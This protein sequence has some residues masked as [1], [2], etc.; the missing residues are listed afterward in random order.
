MIHVASLLHDDVIDNAG[1]R[2]PLRLLHT[3]ACAWESRQSAQALV[4]SGASVPKC[5]AACVPQRA[6]REAARRLGCMDGLHHW[7]RAPGCMRADVR[8]GLRA[9][10]S[11]FGNKIAVLAG[12]FLLARASVSLAALR[13][14]EVIQLLSQVIEDLVTGEILQARAPGAWPLAPRPVRLPRHCRFQGGVG[15]ACGFQRCQ[16]RVNWGLLCRPMAP[17]AFSNSICAGQVCTPD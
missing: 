4:S 13:N 7:C 10:N 8:R 3:T 5:A 16:Y 14:T 12:D 1:G 2:L 17:N 9:L 15:G 6:H 11:V